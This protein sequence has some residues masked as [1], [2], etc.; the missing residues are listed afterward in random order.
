MLRKGEQPTNYEDEEEDP[1]I[2]TKETSVAEDVKAGGEATAT[3][4]EG[5]RQR[6][7]EASSVKEE[8][9]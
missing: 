3:E 2:E 7:V 9:K 6:N 8:V 1:S 4:A 5:I